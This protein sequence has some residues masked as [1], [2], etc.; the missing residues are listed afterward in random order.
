M[1]IALKVGAVLALAACVPAPR[2]QGD[3]AIYEA[4]A[5]RTLVL[6]TSTLNLAADG[7]LDGVSVDGLPVAGTWAVRDGLWC[8]SLTQPALVAGTACERPLFEG[9]RV[10]FVRESGTS[11]TYRIR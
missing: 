9:D 11:I 8:R 4:L 6:G 3:R 5:N 1:H 10:T 2:A 7:R